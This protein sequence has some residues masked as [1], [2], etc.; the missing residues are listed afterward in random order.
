VYGEDKVEAGTIINRGSCVRLYQVLA[1]S[2]VSRAVL[3]ADTLAIHD[4]W[5]CVDPSYFA[6]PGKT[7]SLAY[8]YIS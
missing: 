1:P 7:I 8:Y 2:L 4:D 6:A 3:M 5:S